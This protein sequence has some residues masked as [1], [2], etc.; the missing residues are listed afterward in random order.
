MPNIYIIGGGTN[1]HIRPHLA[2]SAP[3]YGQTAR[4][5]LARCFEEFEEEDNEPTKWNH[6]LILTKMAGGRYMSGVDGEWKYYDTNDD[7][8]VLVDEIVA[9]PDA[10]VVFMTAALCD[11]EVEDIHRVYEEE[12]EHGTWVGHVHSKPGKDLPRLK[13]SEH[14]RLSLGEYNSPDDL[15]EPSLMLHLVP[16]AKII[17][18]IRKI[19][20]DIFLV[21][22]KST[23]GASKQEQFEAG[24]ALMKQSSCN[25]VLANDLHT[26]LNM[27]ITPEQAKYCV[28][29]KRGAAIASLVHIAAN[30]CQG[31]FTRTTVVAGDI[32]PWNSPEIPATLREVVNHCIR[33]GAYQ[34]FMDKTVGHFAARIGENQYLTSV[35]K[36]NFNELLYA[37]SEKTGLVKIEA[38]GDDEVIAYGAKPSVGGQSQRII[39][40]EHPGLDCIAHAHAQL[41]PGS[42]VPVRSQAPFECG[43]H[44]C[45]SNTSSGLKEM[46]SGIWAV[47][48]EKHGFNV[49]FNRAED[50]RRVIE[51]IDRNFLLSRQTSEL[52]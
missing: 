35:R 43:S 12:R 23:T 20:K 7:I 9:D 38:R 14:G 2:L 30:R 39:F 4:D 18:K 27:V 21:G 29:T 48:L 44:E 47:M 24:L 40:A 52:S 46:E 1:F 11:F 41:K 31:R 42:L 5:I 19:R 22:F 8:D 17:S 25:L 28:T 49:V 33:E 3:A 32:V 34:Q 51:F 10:K 45:G 15:G 16:S 36:T 50:P 6:K 13:T 26:R 37:P